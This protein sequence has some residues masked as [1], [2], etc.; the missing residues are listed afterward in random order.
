MTADAWTSIG[1]PH[2][3]AGGN[4]K[5]LF[6]WAGLRTR[7]ELGSDRWLVR[8]VEAY[9]GVRPNLVTS[10][11]LYSPR[12][13]DRLSWLS[14]TSER[15]GV[16]LDEALIK[17]ELEKLA[18]RIGPDAAF[19][20]ALSHAQL[21]LMATP[22]PELEDS[23]RLVLKDLADIRWQNPAAGEPN[24]FHAVGLSVIVPDET[25]HIR[26][27]LPSIFVRIAHDPRL[28]QGDTQ[29]LANRVGDD[30]IF[31]SSHGLYEGTALLGPY[32]GPLLGAMTPS[33]WAVAATRTFGTLL[34]HL[35]R[36]IAGTVGNASE[37]LQTIHRRGPSRRYK[38]PDH[39]HTDQE[40]IVRWWA[41]R[42]NEMFGVISDPAVF[43]SRSGQYQPV[44]HLTTILTM[45]QIFERT[46]S[47]LVQH[48]DFTARMSLL[49]NCLDS[50]EGLTNRS[51]LKAFT[52]GHARKVLD[53]VR[54]AMPPDTHVLLR[55]VEDA[56]EA[57]AEIQTGFAFAR[58]EGRDHITW[59]N[60]SAT[61]EDAAA[62][63]LYALRNSTHGH[64]GSNRADQAERDTTLLIQHNG[65]IPDDLPILALLYLFEMLV[66]PERLR[67]IL[68]K[69]HATQ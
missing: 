3:V 32:I 48:A 15:V 29:H 35:G 22:Q 50:L 7:R 2:W 45:E 17:A 23:A 41:D 37:P 26:L 4:P 1:A 43:R 55:R 61:L 53:R 18:R 16:N 65:H 6:E 5:Q 52:I 44:P 9:E 66:D 64:G 59:G 63:Y 58:E 60:K 40:A 36:G 10:R 69:R 25:M 34:L 47:M 56:V 68:S 67:V 46:T 24:P 51:L 28:Q 42:L 21:R 27:R 49:F 19:V 30:L 39:V 13:G 62:Y 11:T 33:V 31:S 38:V 14:R 12:Q 54:T 8:T 57:L 20:H